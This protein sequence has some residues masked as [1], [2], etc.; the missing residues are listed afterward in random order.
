M[1]ANTSDGDPRLGTIL[2][3]ITH[4]GRGEA[5]PVEPTRDGTPFDDIVEALNTLSARLAGRPPSGHS[6]EKLAQIFDSMSDGVYIADED[7][8]IHYVN[9]AAQAQ[10]GPFGDDKC[11]AYFH[12]RDTPCPSCNNPAVF[13]GESVRWESSHG[14]RHYEILDT[15][16][17]D[18]DGRFLK[19]Q[20]NRDITERKRL[21]A[22][23][24]RTRAQL[25]E[26]VAERTTAL[27]KTNAAL[28]QRIA[29][30]ART[31]AALS[32]SERKYRQLWENMNDAAFIA[33]T[34]TGRIVETNKQGE[35][36]LGRSRDEIIGMHQAQ[37]HPPDRRATYQAAFDRHSREGGGIMRDV[38][39]Y[40]RDGGAVAVDVS[41]A[42]VTMGD[43]TYLL[44]IFHDI[45]ARR[46]A[47]RRVRETRDQ[48]QALYDASPDIILVHGK[49]GP[50]V[51]AN[52]NAVEAYGFSR[53]ELLALPFRDRS[54]VEEGFTEERAMALIARA[55]AGEPLDFEW[56]AKRKN[57]ETFPVEVRLRRLGR[58]TK[59]A[60]VLAV[61]RDISARKHLERDRAVHAAALERK[62]LRLERANAE[63]QQFSYV[64]SHDLKAPLRA[65]SNLVSVMEEDL[66][67]ALPETTRR[68]MHTLQARVRHM[69]RLVNALL[70][71]ARAGNHC[72]QKLTQVDCGSLVRKLVDARVPAQRF[73]ITVADD[74]PVFEADPT[75]LSR[76]LSNLI[77]NAID[78]HDR[79][80]GRIHISADD[81]GEHC[82][83]TVS[84]DGP[85]IAPEHHHRIFDM[86]EVLDKSKIGNTG[87]GLALSRKLVHNCGG[88]IWLDSG[89]GEGT[90][91]HF[92]WPKA[93]D[94][95][96]SSWQ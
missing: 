13:S 37:L 52:H 75:P 8:T 40:R 61:V 28:R 84:D 94:A 46:A 9:P 34:Q 90:R 11:Y 43:K 65:A 81:E 70:D 33:D 86:F 58:D 6:R 29:E 31:E 4:L 62:T 41:A 56:R 20:L 47:E 7:Y 55:R 45:T 17:Y 54:A 14:D 18:S 92:T 50:L 63:L 91:F 16:F 93:N 67:E 96:R 66:G 10:F 73:S 36:L 5:F 64:V 12:G 24:H 1:S 89:P 78:H 35:R 95:C 72:C 83:F 82:R 21:E 15:P 53:E 23:L 87:I 30:H 74:M 44:G 69:D 22:E 88:R 39:A 57:G 25:E 80:D 77:D 38:E 2:E 27:A 3:M 51:D 42:P 48:L 71:Y 26:K 79:P 59:G 60:D 49:D 68:H 32:E 76:V 85:G 19:L